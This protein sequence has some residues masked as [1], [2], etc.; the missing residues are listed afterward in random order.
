MKKIDKHYVSE[1][2]KKMMAF[3][4]THPL[5]A[6]QKAEIKKYQGIYQRRDTVIDDV[7]AD[8]DNLWA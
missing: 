4:A 1:I 6:E 3:N 7:A 2:D 8:K 5:S